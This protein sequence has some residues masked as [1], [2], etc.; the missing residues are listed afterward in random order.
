M[1]AMGAQAADPGRAW[2]VPVFEAD[3]VSLPALQG[4]AR[5]L[6]Q[7]LCPG[8]LVLLVG[9]L[10]AG[11]TAFVREVA[12]ALGV[13]DAVRSPSFTL[14]N[15]YA[16]QLTVHHLDLY[17]LDSVGESDALAVEEYLSPAAVTLVEWPQAGAERLGEA[18]WVVWLEH[19]TP[20]T[21]RLAIRA[22][23][24]STALRWERTGQDPA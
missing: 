18:T 9:P 11:K 23:D 12:G 8:D 5:R 4:H 20:E 6:A 21:R 10:G 15:V 16:G 24:A 2:G 14:A 19:E 22:R 1:V 3:T 13:T 17:R 7:A